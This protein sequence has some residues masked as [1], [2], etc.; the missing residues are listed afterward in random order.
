MKQT[1]KVSA[2]LTVSAVTQIKNELDAFGCRNVTQFVQMAINEKLER[3]IIG[4]MIERSTEEQ[5]KL[6]GQLTKLSLIAHQNN[7]SNNKNLDKLATALTKISA[8]F[9]AFTSRK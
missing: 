4:K 2:R 9:D 7:E 1:I 8:G 6:N 3:F 5:K